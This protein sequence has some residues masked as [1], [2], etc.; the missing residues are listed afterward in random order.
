MTEAHQIGQYVRAH[1]ER[2]GL[3]QQALADKLGCSQPAISQLEVGNASLSIATLQRIAEALG[4]DLEVGFVS[5]FSEAIDRGQPFR[6]KAEG[7]TA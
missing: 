1:R 4:Y 3:S 6:F 5:S 7:A 2:A